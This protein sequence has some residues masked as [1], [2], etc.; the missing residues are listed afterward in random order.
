MPKYDLKQITSRQWL[1]IIGFGLLILCIHL[2]GQHHLKYAGLNTDQYNDKIIVAKLAN[3]GL[4]ARDPVFSNAHN[5]AFYA[6]TPFIHIIGPLFFT[7][8]FYHALDLFQ[9]WLGLVYFLSM[10]I[11]LFRLIGRPFVAAFVAII[12]GF[13]VQ[14]FPLDYWGAYSIGMFCPAISFWFL[15]HSCLDAGGSIIYW[16]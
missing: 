6:L 14:V 10:F 11:F 3:P 13:T 12:S 16:L 4:Y 1:I 2:W 9:P 7:M 15:C 8:D 5:M